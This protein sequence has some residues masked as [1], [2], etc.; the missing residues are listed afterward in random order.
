MLGKRQNKEKIQK[1]KW[2]EEIENDDLDNLEAKLLDGQLSEN[3]LK[4]L[5]EKNEDADEDDREFFKRRK[6]EEDR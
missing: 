5:L 3:E 4:S 6:L 2:M 1:K